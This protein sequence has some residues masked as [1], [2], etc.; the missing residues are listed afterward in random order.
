[1]ASAIAQVV[2][3]HR[4]QIAAVIEL[5]GVEKMR[6]LYEKAR[7]DIEAQLSFLRRAGKG[8]TFTAQHLRMVLLQVGDGIRS[9]QDA[10]GVHLTREG[11]LAST[12]AQ[13]HLIQTV[14]V[15]E[16]EFTGLAPAL[17]VDRAAILRGVRE[18]IMPSLLERYEASKELY[19]LPAIERMKD[20]MAQSIVQN[21]AVDTTVNRLVSSEGIFDG[22]RWRAERIVRT[23]LAYTYGATTQATMEQ[24]RDRDLPGMMKRL[25]ATFDERTGEDSEELDGQTVPV[26]EP[27]VWEYVTKHGAER[28][29]Y[30]HPPN[31]PNDREAVVPWSPGWNADEIGEQGPT[32]V[33]VTE[34]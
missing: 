12:L 33:E 21:E 6:V 32:G 7:A 28:V 15:C 29:E 5:R 25:V 17:S 11:Q 9:F 31:R 10:M 19:G 34:E 26:D 3:L 27:F 8:Q 14:K 4:Q 16:R 20:T 30:M 22:E 13:R 1:M 23:E 18:D 24:M 2:K